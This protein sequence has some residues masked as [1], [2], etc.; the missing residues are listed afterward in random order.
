MMLRIEPQ[1]PEAQCRS[2]PHCRP[3]R[4]LGRLQGAYGLVTG[5]QC[6]QVCLVVGPVVGNNRQIEK[7]TVLTGKIEIEHT[8]NRSALPQHIVAKEVG[9]NDAAR[10]GRII[11]RRLKIELCE[12]STAL[13]GRQQ[14]RKHMSD[15]LSPG[16]AAGVGQGRWEIGAR[17]MQTSQHVAQRP[18]LIDCRCFTALARQAGEQGGRFTRQAAPE[19][20]VAIGQ[21][22][23][24]G[25]TARRQMILR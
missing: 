16:R 12:Q 2:A 14:R 10:Q 1:Q 18:T 6:A 20:P 9:M 24:T 25:N 8:G 23:R 19:T 22:A 5:Q 15:R 4:M 3:G 11:E 21:R 7:Q 17:L 13:V